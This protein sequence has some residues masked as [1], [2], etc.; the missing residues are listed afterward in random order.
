MEGWM[1]RRKGGRKEG[2]MGGREGGLVTRTGRYLCLPSFFPQGLAEFLLAAPHGALGE[3]QGHV[4]TEVC[5]TQGSFSYC[6]GRANA[7]N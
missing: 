6:G 2:S 5:L 7:S 4:G 1:D 3:L